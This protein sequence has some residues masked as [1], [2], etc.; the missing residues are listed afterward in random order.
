VSLRPK[1][2]RASANKDLLGYLL[3]AATAVLLVGGLSLGYANRA[4]ALDP[5]SL[6][7]LD[8]APPAITLILVESSDAFEPRHKRRLR[9]AIEDEAYRLPKH[10]RLLLLAMR[11]DSP[12]EPRALFSKCNPGDGRSANPLFANPTQVQARWESGFLAPLQAAVGR[13]PRGGGRRGSHR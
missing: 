6:C 11:P 1:R 8:A 9:A 4:P 3:I 13:R 7:R 12:R 2:K 5:E 10:G